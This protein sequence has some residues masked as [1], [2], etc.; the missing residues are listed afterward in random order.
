MIIICAI[1]IAVSAYFI[2]SDSSPYANRIIPEIANQ[3]P[4]FAIQLLQLKKENRLIAHSSFFERLSGGKEDEYFF[5][6]IISYEIKTDSLIAEKFIDEGVTE[7]IS[8]PLLK[9]AEHPVVNQKFLLGTDK[10]G[11]DIASRLIVGTRV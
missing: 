8:F 11:R 2:A 6:P 1:V 5:V 3:K 10:F 7:R 9:L 4:G